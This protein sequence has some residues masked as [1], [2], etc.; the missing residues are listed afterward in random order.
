MISLFNIIW[1]ALGIS[2]AVKIVLE[3]VDKVILLPKDREKLQK[4]F[5]RWW[6]DVKNY[7][8]LKFAVA[9]AAKTNEFLNRQFGQP[10][11]SKRVIFKSFV[12]SNAL[13]IVVLSWVGFVDKEPFGVTPWKNYADSANIIQ[14][15][16]DGIIYRANVTIFPSAII[17]NAPP[18]SETTN[19]LVNSPINATAT[20]VHV[21]TNLVVVQI[22]TNTCVV[23]FNGTAHINLSEIQPLGNGDI[24]VGYDRFFDANMR[25]NV[26]TNVFG[27]V[28]S[29]MKPYKEMIGN[30]LLV[31]KYVTEHDT[32]NDILAYSIFYFLLLFIINGTTFTLSLIGCRIMLREIVL[33]AR[34]LST[35]ALVITN[36]VSLSF[37]TIFLLLIFTLLTIP[38]LWILAPTMYYLANESIYTFGAFLVGGAIT[39]WLMSGITSKI[40]VL[41]ALIPSLIAIS[42]GAI[43]AILIKWRTFFHWVVSAILIRL[44]KNGPIPVILA[45]ITVTTGLAALVA[46]WLHLTAFI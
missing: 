42:V 14:S 2:I 15:V 19:L 7:N 6:K 35:V 9:C 36:L 33:A 10:L 13:L 27:N 22:G 25:T 1:F 20:P 16:M 3:F 23:K 26:A 45:T 11:I 32:K 18:F 21:I 43:S 17:S 24:Y 29:T 41:I 44:V 34:V 4:Q 40:I 37:A 38:L 12:L 39:L 8:S 28:E 31:K 30:A 5:E 46:K